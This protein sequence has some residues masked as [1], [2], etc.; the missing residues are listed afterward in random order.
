V[1]L[2]LE[3]VD[4]NSV[5]NG[6]LT[7][8][9]KMDSTH[10]YFA[11]ITNDTNPDQSGDSCAFYFE[12]N[13]ANSGL[14]DSFDKRLRTYYTGAAWID[15]WSLGT[16]GAWSIQGSLPSGVA[17]VEYFEVGVA[18]EYEAQIPRSILN[19]S[20]NFDEDNERIGFAVIVENATNPLEEWPD[21][22]QDVNIGNSNSWGELEI[23]E[24]KYALIP[25]ISTIFIALF[26]RR[27]TRK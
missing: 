12:T 1:D 18:M 14:T 20:F 25:M 19:D 10:V 3:W 22:A 6:N 5:S 27:R 13:H 16:P 11:V 2:L 7:V 26:W 17:I 4:A 24:F 23:P 21:G 8:Y 9:V 15:D